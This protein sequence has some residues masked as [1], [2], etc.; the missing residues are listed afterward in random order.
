MPPA[1]HA[2]DVE[3]QIIEW[4][5]SNWQE[6][7]D[8]LW[9]VR[10]PRRNFVHS[11][12]MAWVAIDRAIGSVEAMG[13]DAPLERFKHMRT[14][15]HDDVCR[16]GYDAER[17]TFTQYY[18]SRQLDAALLLI[19]QVG[20]LPPSDPRVVG[21]VDAVQRELV[22]DGFVMRYIPD[23]HAADGLPPGEGAFLACSFWLADAY[24]LMGRIDDARQLF[25]RLLTLRNDVGLLAEEYDTISKRLL[26]NFPQ[27]FSHIG[28]VNTAYNL[29][30]AHGPAHY[31]SRTDAAKVAY[32]RCHSTIHRAMWQKAKDVTLMYR[33]PR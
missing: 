28:L 16:K 29:T 27:A 31:V 8:G 23:E 26:G 2:W 19:P 5:E 20:F 17:N 25:E 33:L 1:A 12:V 18:G 13:F 10:G 9:E 32:R 24:V 7:D 22:R 15:I 3:R 6:P 11:K 14:A 21:T 4:L 30:E